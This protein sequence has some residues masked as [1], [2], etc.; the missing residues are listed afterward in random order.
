MSRRASIRIPSGLNLPVRNET[1][2]E[3]VARDLV[4]DLSTAR[5]L[6]ATGR[7]L[8]LKPVAPVDETVQADE[9]TLIRC[10]MNTDG[11]WRITVNDA[12]GLIAVGDLRLLVEPKIPRTHLFHLFSCSELVPRFEPTRA[13]A[14]A[15]DHL[16]ELVAAWYLTALEHVLRLDL[17]RDYLP[18]RDTLGVARGH[19]DPVATAQLY[20][21]GKLQLVCEFEEFGSDTPLNRVLKAASLILARSPELSPSTRRRALA[22]SSRMDDVGTLRNA[23]L[24]VTVDR[25]SAHY[26]DALGLAL[27]ILRNVRRTLEHGERDVWAFLIRTPELIESGVRNELRQHLEPWSIRKETIPLNG[28][29]M[30]VSPDLVFG[31]ASAIADI[32]YKLAEPRWRRSDLYEVVA[33]ATAAGATRAAIV[34]FRHRDDPRPPAVQ[35]GHIDV[36]HFGWLADEDVPPEA[37]A[38]NLAAEVAAWLS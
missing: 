8:A 7:K 14:A 35:L 18:I 30:S 9:P 24:R 12:V 28:A 3:S 25:R 20:Y 11:T 26:R 38:Q 33:F 17:V 27:N 5:A 1:L 34:E 19:I 29:N 32:K 2:T 23:D 16:W 10:S 15:G 4:L 22:T 13:A 21:G 31:Y 6:V 36:Q 37:A